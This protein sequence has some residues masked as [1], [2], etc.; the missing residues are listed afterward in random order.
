[1]KGKRLFITVVFGFILGIVLGLV[2]P[3]FSIKAAFVGNVYLNLIKMLITPIVFCSVFCGITGIK[4]KKQLGKLG[5]FSIGLFAL[6]FIICAVVTLVICFIAK[7][8]FGVNLV[9]IPQW[10]GFVVA[11]S[12]G[13][14]L[15]KVIPAN[16]LSAFVSGDTLSVILFTLVFAIACIS[17]AQSSDERIRAGV[18]SVETFVNGLKDILY[19]IFQ[20]FMVLTPIGVC[21]LMAYSVAYYGSGLFGGL[22]KYIAVCWFSCIFCFVFVLFLPTVLI[23]KVNPVKLL[24]SCLK[25]AS[26]AMATTSS[27]ATLPTT[28]KTCIEDLGVSENI[29][30]F[31]SPLG[32]T[33]HMC[34]GACSFMCLLMFSSY[35]YGVH[36]SAGALILGVLIAVLMNM[37]APGIPGGGIVLG[38]SFL[39]I[40][41]LP[42][43]LIGPYAGIYRL[44][45]MIYTTMNVEG[46]VVANLLISRKMSK[47]DA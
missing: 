31:V 25:V 34:G 44:L 27:A 3:D 26:V 23:T 28:I 9:N 29:V 24:K 4:D 43:E 32:C 7:P 2:C 15:T 19:R 42:I 21:S 37:A 22:A 46:D 17:L 8:G 11:P 1:M 36:L 5:A 20:W 30:N 45:D 39:T 12:V 10:D 13:S 14:F 18:S 38:A 33:I 40:M 47:N 6:L 16:I 41:G 35:F